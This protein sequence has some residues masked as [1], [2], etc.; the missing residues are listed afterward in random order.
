MDWKAIVEHVDHQPFEGQPA[1]RF[2]FARRCWVCSQDQ[3]VTTA[4]YSLKSSEL[5][6]LQQHVSLALVVAARALPCPN[7]GVIS[8]L[9]PQKLNCLR[10]DLTACITDAWL[11]AEL[12]ALPPYVPFHQELQELQAAANAA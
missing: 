8:N 2:E 4:Q 11:E 7:C 1:M 12:A 5:S 6:I 3:T 10:R 9:P